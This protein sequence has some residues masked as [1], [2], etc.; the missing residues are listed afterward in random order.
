[1]TTVNI[2][3]ALPPDITNI[4]GFAAPTSNLIEWDPIADVN[5]FSVN[6][7]RSVTNDRDTAVAFGP[8]AQLSSQY[9][10]ADAAAGTTYYYWARSVNLQGQATGNWS[11]GQFDGLAITTAYVTAED[12]APNSIS[13]VSEVSSSDVTISTWNTWKTI[14]TT[15][16]T[17]SNSGK[18][19]LDFNFEQII[20]PQLANN[21]YY[22]VDMRV[23]IS[24]DTG[25][26]YQGEVPIAIQTRGNSTADS[27]P[28]YQRYIEARRMVAIGTGNYTTTIKLRQIRSSNGTSGQIQVRNPNI[29]QVALYK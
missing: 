21:S 13:Q 11:S 1:M 6:V 5:L 10:D 4:S 14:A 22:K 26:L 29:I 23:E 28:F 7:Y 2:Q 16:T 15:T 24:D 9:V 12:I 27:A 18:M 3:A 17:T 19:I 20:K 25:I 8:G